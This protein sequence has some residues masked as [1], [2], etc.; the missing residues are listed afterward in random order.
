MTRQELESTYGVNR[1]GVI[2][3]RGKFQ[4]EMIFAPFYYDAGNSGR[5]AKEFGNVWYF[6]VQKDEREIFPELKDCFGIVV[7]LD[8]GFV[9]STTFKT[10][11]EYEKSVASRG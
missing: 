4:G 10:R 3:T 7:T 2:R 9:F 6:E 1:A 11:G 8:E 5:A